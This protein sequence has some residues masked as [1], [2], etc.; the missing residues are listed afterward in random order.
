MEPSAPGGDS[1]CP[2]CGHLLWW[3]RDR[4]GG[5]PNLARAI[6][7]ETSFAH[8]LGLDSLAMVELVMELDEEFEFAIPADATDE[9]Q[10]VEDAIRFLRRQQQ[11]ERY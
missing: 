6:T 3:F 11:G 10:T 4:L 9:I 1:C 7:L 5:E 8:D 2:A